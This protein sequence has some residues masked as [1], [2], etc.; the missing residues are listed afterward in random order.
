MGLGR[1]QVIKYPKI[2]GISYIHVDIGQY[3]ATWGVKTISVVKRQ[4]GFSLFCLRHWVPLAFNLAA[5]VPSVTIAGVVPAHAW[6]FPG[7]LQLP[8][9]CW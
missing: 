7:E 8:Q 3:G 6:A 1:L 2:H 9:H 4:K 5:V